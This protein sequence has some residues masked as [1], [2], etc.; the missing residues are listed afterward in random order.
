MNASHR[1]TKVAVVNAG[2]HPE[3]V[4][5]AV[6]LASAD[7]DVRYLSASMVPYKAGRIRRL[8]RGRLKQDVNA[9]TLPPELAST[10]TYGL[11]LDL[12]FVAMSRTSLVSSATVLRWRNRYFEYRAAR[13]LKQFRADIVVAQQ[14]VAKAVFDACGDAYKILNYPIAH[15]RWAQ[16]LYEAEAQSNPTWSAFIQGLNVP[17]AEAALLDAEIKAADLVLVGSTFVRRTFLEAGVV[18][19]KLE[20]VPLGA[21]IDFQGHSRDKGSEVSADALR[22]L[23]AGQVNQRKGVGYLVDALEGM[24]AEDYSIRWVG[25]IEPPVRA[26]L[27]GR[28]FTDIT[29]AVSRAS[30][31]EHI[32][33]ADVVVLPSLIEG[34]PL[35]AIE[36]MAAGRV[37]V[38][39]ENT[40]GEDVITPGVDGLIVKPADPVGLRDALLWCIENRIALPP[41]GAA[42]RLRAEDFTWRKYEERSARTISRRL[43]TQQS[44]QSNKH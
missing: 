4:H 33:Q 41:M 15:H 35:T 30:M 14:T 11:A 9:R 37:L 22:I 1:R 24:E 10:H 13:M 25:P 5:L 27:V 3:L 36:T 28:G 44:R 40:F 16:D 42:A 34:F 39:S 29:G 31:Q 43:E 8:L 19:A 32:R 7:F 2:T 38:I 20:V 12:I 26:A 21:D 18:D 23:F 6:G 17:E